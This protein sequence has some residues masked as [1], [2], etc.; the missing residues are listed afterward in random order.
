MTYDP[1]VMSCE[2]ENNFDEI[3]EF[4]LQNL[5]MCLSGCYTEYNI[6]KTALFYTVS[7]VNKDERSLHPL[8]RSTSQIMEGAGR[9]KGEKGRRSKNG[10]FSPAFFPC[11]PGLGDVLRGEENVASHMYDACRTTNRCC[12]NTLMPYSTGAQPDVCDLLRFHVYHDELRL[13]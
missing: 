5:C 13:A 12:S 9:I 4:A 10:Y 3:C 6:C 8:R 11:R 1:K 7:G 2:L